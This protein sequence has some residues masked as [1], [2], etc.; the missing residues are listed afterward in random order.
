MTQIKTFL[1]EQ[2]KSFAK[3]TINLSRVGKRA[4]FVKL[5]ICK[6]KIILYTITQKIMFPKNIGQID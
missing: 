4:E 2:K 6:Q 3:K 5:Q 1:S